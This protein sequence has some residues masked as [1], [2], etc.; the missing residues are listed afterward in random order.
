VNAEKPA[1]RPPLLS[2]AFGRNFEVRTMNLKVVLPICLVL[3]A[4]VQ[5]Q[6]AD[7]VGSEKET[8]AKEP[9]LRKELLAMENE[10]QDIRVAVVK[11]LGQKGISLGD[12]KP[13]TDPALLRIFLEQSGKM[14]AVDQKNRD[15]LK[16][17]VGKHGWPGKSLAG[18]DGAHAAWLLAQHADADLALQKRCLGL[19]KAA[20][21]GEVEPQ[22]IAYLTDRILVGEKKNQRYGTQLVQQGGRFVPQPIEDEANVDNRRADVGLPPLAEYLKVAQ[23]EY[24]KVVGKK[25]EKK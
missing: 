8:A 12:A 21:K 3:T 13:I 14:T 17:I 4:S 5:R 20:P 24:D 18:R 19:M 7:K 25:S 6:D 1:S 10:D 9:A 16:K 23:A 22:D 15:R 11:A 2:F